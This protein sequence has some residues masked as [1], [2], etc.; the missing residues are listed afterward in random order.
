MK[1]LATE[2][3]KFDFQCEIRS[4]EIPNF[5]GYFTFV[6]VPV[7]FAQAIHVFCTIKNKSHN[8][9]QA[10]PNNLNVEASGN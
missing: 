2:F 7:D 8:I 4:Y 9:K 3:I 1:P 6:T 10:C 5:F